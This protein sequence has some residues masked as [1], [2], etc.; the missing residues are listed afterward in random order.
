M[1]VRCPHCQS[2]IE[3]LESSS[4]DSVDCGSCGSI[5]SLLSEDTLDFSAD[6]S[7]RT[8]GHFELVEML[9]HGSHGSVW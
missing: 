6:D 1:Q 3:V 5:F 2:A 7:V 4:L 9:G 8:L